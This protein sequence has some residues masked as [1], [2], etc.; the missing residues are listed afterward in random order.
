MLLTCGIGGNVIR[1]IPPLNVS[2]DDIDEA[3]SI[4]DDSLDAAMESRA[5]VALTS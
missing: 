1:W 2:R 3:I 5:T 4:F